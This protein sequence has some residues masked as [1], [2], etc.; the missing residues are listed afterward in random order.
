MSK[1]AIAIISILKPVNDSRNFEKTGLSISQTNK[2]A[3]NIIGFSAK[4]IPEVKNIIFHPLFNFNRTHPS[5]LLTSWKIYKKLLKLK[6]EVIIATTYESLMVICLYKIIFGAKILYDI[7]ENYYRNIRFTST[8]PFLLRLPLALYIRG[9]EKFCNQWIDHY[10]LAE[11]S[12]S[13]DLKFTVGKST[14]IENKTTLQPKIRI[15]KKNSDMVRFTYIGTISDNYGIFDAI[16]FIDRMHQVNSTVHFV[17]AGYCA[18]K[19]I[20]RKIKNKTRGKKYITIHGGEHILPHNQII[21]EIE[22]A[23]FVILPYHLDPSIKRCIPT[24]IYECI[25]LKTPMIIRPNPLWLKLCKQFNACIA[26]DFK[27]EDEIFMKMLLNSNYYTKGNIE[28][29]S[30][31]NEEIK[32]LNI[33]EKLIR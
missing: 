1:V 32:L 23:D 16:A 11:K 20:W 12:Y 10:I 14:I 3:V 21:K 13:H 22:I 28:V 9:I 29:V 30:W 18:K 7:Q 5:R 24:K 4:N 8:Y 33:I 17:I 15:K 26:C 19:N 2:Y 25:A 6:P 27:D 31:K